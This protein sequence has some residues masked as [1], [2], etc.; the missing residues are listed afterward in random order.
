MLTDGHSASWGE[1]ETDVANN[2]NLTD[3][4]LQT[5]PGFSIDTAIFV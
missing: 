5:G 1:N 3:A 2:N 4:V